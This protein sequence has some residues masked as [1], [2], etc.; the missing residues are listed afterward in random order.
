MQIGLSNLSVGRNDY[1][2]DMVGRDLTFEVVNDGETWTRLTR[3][4]EFDDIP[5]ARALMEA[6]L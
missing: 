1:L 5:A 2:D 6:V 4:V 3:V